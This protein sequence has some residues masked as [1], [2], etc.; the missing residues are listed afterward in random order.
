MPGKNEIKLDVLELLIAM[1]YGCKSHTFGF[2]SYLDRVSDF[3]AFFEF[4]KRLS[5]TSKV[6]RARGAFAPSTSH[7]LFM[8]SEFFAMSRRDQKLQSCKLAAPFSPKMGFSK[9]MFS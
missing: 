9:A 7:Q 1:K 3:L 8:E 6:K 5:K 2:P 4:E